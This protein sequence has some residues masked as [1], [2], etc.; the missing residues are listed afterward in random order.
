M[1]SPSVLTGIGEAERL[2]SR[3]SRPQQAAATAGRR[4]DGGP[5]NMSS[6]ALEPWLTQ[7]RAGL[8]EAAFPASFLEVES[9]RA[10]TMAPS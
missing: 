1:D 9:M 5:Q 7:R 6:A 2:E 4:E 3:E 8:V 10:V